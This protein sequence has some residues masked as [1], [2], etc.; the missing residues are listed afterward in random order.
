MVRKDKHP[1]LC[2]LHNAKRM[3][4]YNAQKKKKRE[5]DEM[6][7][8][9]FL[10]PET[11]SSSHFVSTSS[12]SSSS[13]AAPPQWKHGDRVRKSQREPDQML[14]L[15][16]LHVLLV[17][18]CVFAMPLCAARVDQMLTQWLRAAGSESWA[19]ISPSLQ[20]SQ[21]RRKAFACGDSPSRLLHRS[22]SHALF[23][24]CSSFAPLRLPA[25]HRRCLPLHRHGE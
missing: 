15:I 5:G 1:H 24:F 6:K 23:F 19:G 4:K 17:L 12:S 11:P 2:P 21:E 22:L 13:A 20:R 8:E 18:S 14:L 7:A 16:N 25:R 3:K 9:Y 10:T